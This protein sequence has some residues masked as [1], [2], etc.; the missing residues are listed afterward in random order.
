M[1]RMYNEA[2]ATHPEKRY[3]LLKVLMSDA[4]S[5]WSEWLMSCVTQSEGNRVKD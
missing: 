4:T 5:V 1:G 2:Q 3:S